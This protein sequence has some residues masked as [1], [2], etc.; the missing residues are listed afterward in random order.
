MSDR[1]PT[2][3]QTVGPFFSFGLCTSPKNELQDGTERVSGQVFDGDGAPIVDA[4][5]R[6][7]NPPPAIP[8]ILHRS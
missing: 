3:S 7:I 2:P 6:N 5:L 8:E 1:L 4:L